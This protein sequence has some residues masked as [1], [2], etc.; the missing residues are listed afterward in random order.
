MS[1]NVDLVKQ[2]QKRQKRKNKQ[3]DAVAG[4]NS[5]PTS[6]ATSR[7]SLSVPL[8]SRS[9]RILRNQRTLDK[10]LKRINKSPATDSAASSDVMTYEP[11]ESVLALEEGSGKCTPSVLIDLSDLLPPESRSRPASHYFPDAAAGRDGESGTMLGKQSLAEQ[12]AMFKYMS[13]EIAKLVDG[14][15]RGEIIFHATSDCVFLLTVI[16]APVR[17]T[18]KQKFIP[19]YFAVRKKTDT[20]AVA[21][22]NSDRE[23]ANAVLSIECE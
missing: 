1:R 12:D 8:N 21:G 7:R 3:Q 14:N 5:L 4:N 22:K 15:G 19:D 2:K 20:T 17:S 9:K 10:W 23:T 16:A 6:S 13:D 11:D 18:E